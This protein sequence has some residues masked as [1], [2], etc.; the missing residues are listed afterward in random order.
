MLTTNLQILILFSRKFVCF[1]KSSYLK[2]N[3]SRLI[4]F[5][6]NSNSPKVQNKDIQ[7]LYIHR[8]VGIIWRILGSTY[9]LTNTNP[10]SQKKFTNISQ[11]QQMKKI[12]TNIMKYFVKFGI[13][14][15]M[16]D[17]LNMKTNVCIENK[18]AS[19]EI[20]SSNCAGF[21]V[22]KINDD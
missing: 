1:F 12:I 15:G 13:C 19:F 6:S 8:Y 9:L 17:V 22:L 20:I 18:N 5:F 21:F 14:I 16:L 7:N 11:F 10:K 3:P 4:L 2:R